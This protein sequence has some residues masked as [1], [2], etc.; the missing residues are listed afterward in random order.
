MADRAD[1][2]DVE[3]VCG[4]GG[5]GGGAGVQ[6]EEQAGWA[7]GHDSGLDVY[8]GG[9]GVWV[10]AGGKDAGQKAGVGVGTGGGIA[11]M[12]GVGGGTRLEGA[13]RARRV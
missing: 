1:A 5:W 10:G 7:V 2:D 11:T 9:A 8:G 3:V 4:R 6:S 13:V 12:G